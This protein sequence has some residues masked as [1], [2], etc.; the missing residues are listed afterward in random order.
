MLSKVEVMTTSW[1]KAAREQKGW[2]QFE[3]A[4][5][6]GVSQPYLSLLEQGCRPLT[7]RLLSKLQRHF[8]VPATELPVEAPPPNVGAQE[9]AEALGALGYPGFAYLKRGVRWHPA[10]V[11]LTALAQSNLEARLA[12]ALPWVVLHYPNLSWNWL[13]EQ[14]KVK[15]VQNRLGF[16]V[17][18]TRQV[19]ERHGDH[20]TSVRLSGFEQQLERSRLVKE[21]TLGRESMTA[22]ERRWLQGQ[23]SPEAQHWNLL[24]DLVPEH[25]P[26]A[27]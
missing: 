16:I 7:K 9:V 17:T 11:L 22:A 27:F 26:Y 1:L 25:L 6:L 21:D 13:L 19:A 8:E 4:G 14:V 23:R 24:T 10:Q 12:E 18:L 2:T 15:D 5:R 20:S 3:T